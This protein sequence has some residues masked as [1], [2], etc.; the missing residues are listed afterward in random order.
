MTRRSSPYPALTA[1]EARALYAAA[2]SPEMRR[3][4]WEIRRLQDLVVEAWRVSEMREMVA[5]GMV[6]AGRQGAARFRDQVR[7]E[8]CW[9]ED[10]AKRDAEMAAIEA[11]WSRR[12]V[13]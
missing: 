9:I 2:P 5:P 3:A 10:K 6:D 12:R 7:A 1:D 11:S 8:P 13:R 4:L